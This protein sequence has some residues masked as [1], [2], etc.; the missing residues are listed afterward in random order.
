MLGLLHLPIEL[1]TIIIDLATDNK[2][3]YKT[4]YNFSLVSKQWHTAFNNRIY[5]S[6]WSHD[7]ELHLILSLWQF[8]RTTLSNRQIADSVREIN[9]RKW[10]F[11]LVHRRGLLVLEADDL[12]V[13]RHAIR[14][15]GL[16]RIEDKFL[17]A[18]PKAD[19]RPLMALLLA[20]LRNLT[21]LYAELP[22]KGHFP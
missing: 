9:I 18:L 5:N 1:F 6:K 4:L 7:D 19:P 13:I 16:E 3:D 10:T 20:N 14:T 21:T 15:L 2:T 22:E 11:G 17:E 12:D 8:L